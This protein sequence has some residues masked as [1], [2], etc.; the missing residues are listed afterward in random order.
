MS[1]LAGAL[2][3][4]YPSTSA[5]STLK[6]EVDS[7]RHGSQDVNMHSPTPRVKQEDVKP[8][9]QGEDTEMD[10]LFGNDEDVEEV[11]PLTCVPTQQ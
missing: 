8:K 6:R 1:S 10:D 11:Q 3:D 5:Q 2:D 4:Y 7:S 9:L